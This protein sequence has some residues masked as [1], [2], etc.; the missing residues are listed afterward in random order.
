[1]TQQLTKELIF[2][3]AADPLPVAKVDVPEW[4][5]TAYVR[6]MTAR[7]RDDFETSNMKLG[8][9]GKPVPQLAN[10]RGRLAA[11]VLCDEKGHRL[12]TDDDA[13]QLG[14]MAA[15]ALDRVIDA[16]KKLNGMD[17]MAVEDARGNS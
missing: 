4:G 1:M 12:F 14:D 13:S 11:R 8:K 17:A 10:Y 16:A 3:R 2:A 6:S 15:S 5:G 9:D 7:E